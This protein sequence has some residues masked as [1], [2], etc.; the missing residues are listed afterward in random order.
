MLISTVVS[1]NTFATEESGFVIDTDVLYANVPEDYSFD[2]FS[3]GYYSFTDDDSNSLYYLA[4]ENTSAPNGIAKLGEKDIQKIL[5]ENYFNFVYE[6][7]TTKFE[8]SKIKKVNGLNSYIIEGNYY[9]DDVESFIYPFC[10]YIFATEENIIMVVYEDIEDEISDYD[11]INKAVTSIEVNGTFFP[12]D[13]PVNNHDFTG[14]LPFEEA[15]ARDVEE[16]LGDGQVLTDIGEEVVGLTKI[17]TVAIFIIPFAI[18]VLIAIIMIIKYIKNK[19]I[20]DKYENA[21]GKNPVNP[22]MY[23]YNPTMPSNGG[24]SPYNQNFNNPQQ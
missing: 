8:E 1:L 19:K 20:L 3:E 4:F 16:Y 23:N 10:A 2:L 17:I 9:F 12:G 13:K 22:N 24:Y 15:L 7:V 11:D 6:S 21:Y 14:A 18:V 5:N